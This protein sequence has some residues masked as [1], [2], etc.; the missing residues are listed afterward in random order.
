M[1]RSQSDHHQ[2]HHTHV[3]ALQFTLSTVYYICVGSFVCTLFHHSRCRRLFITIIGQY[4]ISIHLYD[5]LYWLLYVLLMCSLSECLYI[6]I[7]VHW[8]LSTV[9]TMFILSVFC[10]ALLWYE[11]WCLFRL[12]VGGRVDVHCCCMICNCLSMKYGLGYLFMLHFVG[13][14]IGYS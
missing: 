11:A 4:V 14:C 7:Y 12:C 8:T 10:A 13:Y 3:C 6:Y 5:C 9:L 2:G 1:F